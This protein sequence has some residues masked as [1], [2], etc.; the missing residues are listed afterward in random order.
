MGLPKLYRDPIHGQLAYEDVELTADPPAV[1]SAEK[2]TSW[3][4]RQ[5]V[6][7][8]IFQRLR[9][10]RQNGLTNLVYHGSEHSRFTHSMGAAQVARAML[11]N[12]DRNMGQRTDDV[13]IVQTIVAALLHDVGHGPF[14]HT[15]EEIL[16]EVE[17]PFDHERMTVRVLTEDGSEVRELIERVDAAWPNQIASYIDKKLR[18]EQRIEEH[19]THKVVSSQLD[20]DRLDYI[21]RDLWAAGIRGHGFDM[22]RL[23]DFLVVVGDTKIG[24]DERSIEALEAYLLS[25][26]QAYRAIY[27]HHATRAASCLLSAVL[28]RAIVLYRDGGNWVFQDCGG[29]ENPIKALVDHGDNVP[30]D[31]YARLGEYHIWVMIEGWQ[32]S[33]DQILSDLCRRMLAR[34]LPK[35]VDIDHTRNPLAI[36][37]FE[38]DI[39]DIVRE[40]LSLASNDDAAFYCALDNPDRL[41]YK[42]YTWRPESAEDSIWVR[43]KSGEQCPLEDYDQSKLV[44]ALKERRFFRRAVVPNEARKRV[45]EVA[46]D[47]RFAP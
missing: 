30:L 7:T 25:L 4:V 31:A 36:V 10:I 43:R 42:Q 24:I 9:H 38:N 12:V 26:D 18:K 2:C 22:P 5:L 20:A 32:T 34:R 33:R 3:L 41:S 35:T 27:Y 47:R 16:G 40:E 37:D 29:Q 21:N 8:P 6:D 15:L 13:S 1:T 23:L 28:R 14:S 19:W 11:R 39:R 44:G 46:R 17:V 45:T